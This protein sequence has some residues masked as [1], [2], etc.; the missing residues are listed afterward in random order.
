MT[1][2]NYTYAKAPFS[3]NEYL[4]SA[5]TK[6]DTSTYYFNKW[7]GVRENG[8]VKL[9]HVMKFY[10]NGRFEFRTFE[11]ESFPKEGWDLDSDA[12]HYYKIEK[13]VL[14]LEVYG[15]Q[16]VGFAYW[17]GNI[18]SDSIVFSQGAKQKNIV[19]KKMK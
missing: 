2:R 6:L 3:L 18:Y 4:K 13:G 5:E 19:Y 14:K 8:N 10:S 1:P 16:L 7:V 15:D 9:V 11:E 12:I 17:K